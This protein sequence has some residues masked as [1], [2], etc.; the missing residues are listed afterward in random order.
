M[1]LIKEVRVCLT[2]HALTSF[3]IRMEDEEIM[4]LTVQCRT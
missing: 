3:I 4:Y 2:W 1:T